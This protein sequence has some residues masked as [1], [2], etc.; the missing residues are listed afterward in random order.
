MVFRKSISKEMKKIVVKAN[1][2]IYL[3]L[4]ILSISK[5][6]MYEYWYND[7]KKKY[8]KDVKLCYIDM[9]TVL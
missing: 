6:K 1:K 8:N 9:D 4:A 7:I 3:G 2:P 5:I